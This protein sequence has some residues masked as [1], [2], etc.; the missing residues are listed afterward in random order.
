MSPIEAV[1]HFGTQVRLAEALGISQS[2]VS[3]WVDRGHIPWPRQFQIQ[4]VSGGALKADAK[5][6]CPPKMRGK[7]RLREA[8]AA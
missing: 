8:E 4:H 6:P 7:K 5:D 3:E 2:S 1:S